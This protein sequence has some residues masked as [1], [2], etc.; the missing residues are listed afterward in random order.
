VSR[1]GGDEFVMILPDLERPEHARVVADKILTDL[2]RPVEIGGQEI[3]VTPSIGISHYPNDATDVHQL[4]KHADNAMY[5]AKDAGRNTVRFF[6]NDLNFL[7]SKRLEIEGRLRKAIENEEF[8]LRYQPQVDIASGRICGMEALI[9]WNDPQKGEIFPKDFIFVA[10]ELGLIVPIGEWVFRTACKQIRQWADDGLVPVTVSINISPRQ[11]MSRKLVSTLL[12]IVRETGADPHHIELEITETMIMRNVEQSIETL[13]RLRSVGM[14]VA[15]DDFGVGYSS[16]SQLKRLPASS[17]KIDRSFIMNVPDDASSGSITEAI[18]AM[19]KRL[20]LRCI[21]EG[22][23]THEQLDFLRAN[24]CE[25][26]QGYLFSRPVT[27]LEAT[28]ML[29]AQAATPTT[30]PQSAVG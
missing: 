23:E 11:F 2:S 13:S 27:A 29:R 28:A 3:H 4:L 8:F 9:R 1:E 5:Q 22:V 24:H 25:A 26:F 10:E 6:T 15:V 12:Q 7:L 16:L 30:Q 17:M 21:A 18:I 19:A 14:H 20:K